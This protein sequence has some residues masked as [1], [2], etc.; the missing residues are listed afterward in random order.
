MSEIVR[1]L[2]AH[3]LDTTPSETSP[4]YSKFGSGVLSLNM[5]YNPN[6]VTE[7]YIDENSG[8]TLVQ[9]YAPTLPVTQRAFPGD[10]IFDFIDG[11]RQI[12]SIGGDDLTTIVEV[13][14]YETPETDG[15]TYPATQW[16]VAIQFESGPGGDGGS[17]AEITYTINVKSDPVPGTFN[18][19]TLAFT[20]D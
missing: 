11:L 15:L 2:V 7:Q 17:N 9:N 14:L 10:A 18:T 12:Q 19:S 6:T 8:H 4:T 20:A 5:S 13:R 3:F 16:D 1:S